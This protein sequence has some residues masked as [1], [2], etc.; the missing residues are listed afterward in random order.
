MS[1]Q[2]A[3]RICTMMMC[4]GLLLSS[5]CANFLKPEIGAVAR[6]EARI[7]LADIPAGTFET[8][9]LRIVYSLTQKDDICT[10]S[11]KIVFDRSL[12]DS[13]PKIAK[14]FLYLSY[15]DD[16]GKVIETVDIT[17]VINT[18]GAAPDS[19]PLKMSRVRPPGSKAFAF[20]YYGEF[21]TNPLSD[22]GQWEIHHF[23]FN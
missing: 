6:K 5:G 4:L 10:L 2:T 16:A 9:D 8:G 15:L 7:N 14:F 12:S 20:H 1:Q 19:L 18:F 17:P 23:P 11:G 13:F 22:G 21:Q 3:V